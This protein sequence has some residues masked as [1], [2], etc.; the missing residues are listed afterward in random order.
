MSGS[1]AGSSSAISAA[2]PWEQVTLAVSGFGGQRSAL[3]RVL[4]DWFEF[5]GGRPG[6]VIYVDGGSG[7][8]TTRALTSLLHEGVIDKLEL[9]TPSHWENSFHRCYIQE[10]Q[11]G[12]LGTRP[13]LMFIKPDML[14]Y[15]RGFEEWLGEDLAALDRAGVFAVTNT[16]LIDPPAGREGNYLVSDF[17]SLNFALMKK[18]MFD[19]AARAQIGAFIDAGFRGE[20]PA[21]IRTEER[22]RRALIEWVW[23]QHCQ[24]SGLR[25]LG[26]AESRDWTIFHINKGG[27]KLLSIRARYRARDGVESHFDKPK[28][29]YRPPLTGVQRAGRAVESGVRK[30]RDSLLGRSATKAT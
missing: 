2:K 28:G 30:I 7:R 29:L 16:H 18:A 12:R 24:E 20:Y 14:P 27:R 4:L 5:I 13:Y 17:A 15:R 3:R 10:Y 11:A 22:Y 23:Q 8:A 21:H 19:A 1:G 25:T 26:R 6:E 9:L